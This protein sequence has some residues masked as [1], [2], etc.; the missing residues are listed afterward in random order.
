LLRIPLS[1]ISSGSF[2]PKSLFIITVNSG[3]H[4]NLG[5]GGLE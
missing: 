3:A 4:T 1:I 2:H 5:Y